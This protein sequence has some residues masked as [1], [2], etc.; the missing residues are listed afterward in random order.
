MCKIRCCYECKKRHNMCHSHCED[1]LRER[2]ALDGYN[3]ERRKETEIRQTYQ[4]IK[5]E[6]IRRT[7]KKY[8]K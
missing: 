3:A 7:Q 1:Y 4:A 8:G 6:T 2:K 5:D